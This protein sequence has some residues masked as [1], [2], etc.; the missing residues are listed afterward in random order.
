[1]AI[2]KQVSE[3]E[4]RADGKPIITELSKIESSIQQ[5]K[6]AQ[7]ELTKGTKEYAALGKEVAT[8]SAQA[9]KV[10]ESMGIT[11]MTVSQL[12]KLQADLNK[13][14]R[15]FGTNGDKLQEVNTRLH[16]LRSE[17]AST[18]QTVQASEGVWGKLKGW[19]VGAF[20][21][22]AI[23][24]F[25]RAMID[26]G[27]SVF[28]VGA[29][30]EKY[31]VVLA[32]A[33]GSQELAKKSMA[34]LQDLAKKTPFTLDELTGS[35]V[36]FINRGLMPSMESM[37]KLG[38]LAASQ[39]K[40][41]DQLTE[42][43]LDAGTGEF[44]RLKEFGIAAKKN[45]DQVE[46]SFKGVHKT[47]KM[48]PEA[49][50]GA[51]ESFGELDTVS[52]MMAET[53]LTGEG[54]L[55]NI[56][57]KIDAVKV[58]IYNGLMP[59][60]K[61]LFSITN[62][63]WDIFRGFA[64]TLMA[65]PNFVR[66]NKDVFI[67]LGVALATLNYNGII[68]NAT[69]LRATILE[70]GRAAATAISNGVTVLLNNTVRANP[71]MAMVSG[72]MLLVTAL[73]AWYNR[74]ETLRAT[75]SGLW[76]MLKV[77]GGAFVDFY[78]GVLTFNPAKMASAFVGLGD[79]LG[80]AFNEGYKKSMA[81]SKAAAAAEKKKEDDEAARA[82]KE[83][84]DAQAKIEADAKLN[85]KNKGNKKLSE[86]DKNHRDSEAAKALEKAEK[87]AEEELKIRE[88]LADATYKVW[89]DS[90][91]DQ[92]EKKKQA[93]IREYERD[94]EAQRENLANSKAVGKEKEKL[95]ADFVAYLIQLE[96][97]KVV[98][99]AKI[100]QERTAAIEK[101]EAARKKI[102]ATA[103]DEKGK[104]IEAL[105]K[106]LTK[107][108]LDEAQAEIKRNKEITDRRK[109]MFTSLLGFVNDSFNDTIQTLE[110]ID[111]AYAQSQANRIKAIQAGFQQITAA[112]GSLQIDTEKL[113]KFDKNS[114][115]SIGAQ[116]GG[117]IAEG[118][119][120]AFKANPIKFM[121]AA[122]KIIDGINGVF[123]ANRW[124]KFEAPL[125]KIID[126]SLAAIEDM[127]KTLEI[128]M[129][130][131][132]DEGDK[133]L[134]VNNANRDKLTAAALDYEAK[135]Y[136]MLIKSQE[137]LNRIN[138][139]YAEEELRIKT[140]YAD[141]LNSQ[142]AERAAQAREIVDG[143]IHDLQVSRNEELE[144]LIT[145]ENAKRDIQK[146]ADAEL[147]ELAKTANTR[148]VEEQAALVAA[149]ELK[150]NEDLAKLKD[151]EGQKAEI[152]RLADEAAL[153]A[154]TNANNLSIA[155]QQRLVDE[156]EAK[157]A[158]DL[159]NLATSD[160]G[161]LAIKQQ[162]ADAIKKIEEASAAETFRIE[163]E[164]KDKQAEAQ[165]Q[166]N[167]QVY[168]A[169]LA[170]F[171]AEK[172]LTIAMLQLQ[173][174]KAN[175]KIFNKAEAKA[176]EAALNEAKSSM[177][178]P[179]PAGIFNIP[180]G[181]SNGT[182]AS[183]GNPTNDGGQKYADGGYVARGKGGLPA[184]PLHS[185]GGIWMWN[186]NTGQKVG[187]LEGGEYI[188]NRRAT[189][190]NLALI[191]RINHSGLINKVSNS[192][193]VR[194]GIPAYEDGGVFSTFAPITL[195]QSNSLADATFKMLEMIAK[196]TD[197][198]SKA[199]E[200]TAKSAAETASHS[201]NLGSIAD[202]TRATAN[203]DFSPNISI[204]QQKLQQLASIESSARL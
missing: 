133:L 113:F 149:V 104:E 201:R 46:L 109:E 184:G 74:S 129:K 188:V 93:V 168:A 94:K 68:N 181:G 13:E 32:K 141:A 56:N 78:A 203:K 14:W 174:I 202:A 89:L 100:D 124:A 190:A 183:G 51:I 199:A 116:L 173:L 175:G 96:K 11:S 2:F 166:H 70:K 69:V 44:E 120:N 159:A 4:I 19:I 52:G 83:L 157:R 49:M 197:A 179:P 98:S 146:T 81:V 23:L 65:V 135:Q 57:D 33:F 191:S 194:T 145:T 117:N 30:F 16:E 63:G 132:E 64:G 162:T 156:I 38:D 95:E 90:I 72:V 139:E 97:N 53:M 136:A 169:Q 103:L 26:F 163:S 138:T 107:D 200:N 35:Y 10:R 41:F 114:S 144:N 172:K 45:G 9:D 176:I 177:P 147:A 155:E 121:A 28:D 158:Q 43:I 153:A 50:Q 150:R 99:L 108:G 5:A 73:V 160:L 24:E 22:G 54:N 39:G 85:G 185:E 178:P 36:K 187:E 192:S 142:D 182:P 112:V 79:R 71:V 151:Y 58:E 47:V 37:T 101:E 152:N 140:L 180:S 204:I 127:G 119:E 143:L 7:A 128:K 31:Q 60:F 164:L 25:G 80:K 106:K 1:M 34:D 189:A 198:T 165:R 67:G 195:N 86:A 84:A 110:S 115:D 92:W 61:T 193:F 154:K 125:R 62:T 48:T 42:A 82:A 18:H 118:L 161:I 40:G 29:K 91:E 131:L 12:T 3:T 20:T 27:K 17:V 6:Q 134:Q 170:E 15:Q 186:P 148:T 87:T 55:S 123:E 66:E 75:L 111:S 130:S 102:W 167:L 8:L 196:A 21:I 171:E 137:D 76:G 88:K 59:V 77:L 122:K 126:D 105:G